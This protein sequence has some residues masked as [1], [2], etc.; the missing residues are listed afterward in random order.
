MSF[1][2]A[3]GGLW[4]ETNT[5]AAGRTELE[6]FRAYQFARG[7]E[8][9]TRYQNVRNEIGGMIAGARV[10]SLTLVPTLF[11]G[12]VPSGIVARETFE[13]L[14]TWLLDDLAAAGD[15]DGVL[16]VLH[17]AMVA[18]GIPDAAS[19][20]QQH[21]RLVGQRD[22][23]AA[24]VEG[25]LLRRVRALIGHKPLVAT[26]D[27]HA[28]LSAEMVEQADVLIGYD[29]YPHVDVYERGVE[30]AR[31][32]ARILCGEIRPT[33][34]FEALPLLSVPQA[35]H[36]DES[37]LR[38]LMARRAEIE[39]DPRVITASVAVGF[40]YA[41][42]ARAGM[43]VVVT[44][45]GD[46]AC[47]REY[48][49]ELG[50]RIWARRRE[51]QVTNVPVAEAVRRAVESLE[52]HSA[53]A[54]VLAPVILVDVADNIGGGAPGDGTVL[55][56]AL[57]DAHAQNAV[58]TIADA[59]AVAQAL[60]AGIDASVTLRVGGKVDSRHGAPVEVRGRVRLISSGEYVHK[61]SYMT[62]QTTR[63]GRTV[64]LDCDGLDLVIMERKT[65]PFDA[66]QLRSLGIEPAD[67]KIIV[68]KSALAWQAAYGAM[69][70][71]V[72]YVDTPGICT[73]NL[74]ALP[75]QNV[76]R[77]IFPLDEI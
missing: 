25:E 17:G 27:I 53:G 46:A 42:V 13:Q 24:D 72:I 20:S 76:R 47:A 39:N 73:A 22:D 8:L 2:V 71:E 60:A 5:F 45:N 75:Y 58:V 43:S 63:M 21:T 74:H 36:T 28:N 29:T 61:G 69:A 19:S 38:E 14:A 70:R 50:E 1:R 26:F 62:G 44:T 67:K 7:D 66:Q 49:Q 16:L 41:D 40:P 10:H 33:A 55:L 4:H 12:A 48:A 3:L 11:A 23:G 52:R 54:S 59:E 31:V 51:F 6:A 37:P 68:V 34:A 15:L 56:Q 32:M 35:Q 57:L 30:A 18:E 9:L 65:M 64:V 77:P